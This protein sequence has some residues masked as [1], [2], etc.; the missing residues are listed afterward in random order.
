V[1]GESVNRGS[2]S[3]LVPVAA[4]LVAAFAVVTSEL[5]P[6]GLLPAIASD[7]EVSIPTAGLLISGYAIGVAIA[8]PALALVTGGVPR[9]LLLLVIMG[10]LILGSILSALSGSYWML[11]GARL[12]V[13]ACHGL[14]FG[15]A[16]VLASQLA[17]A[18]RQATAVSL[19]M[20]GV[21]AATILGVPLG[22]AIGN[23]ATWR[24][25]FWLIVALAVLAT[26]IVALLIPDK[27]TDARA[28]RS[29]FGAELSAALRPAALLCYASIALSMV[30][31]FVI[32]SYIVPFLTIVS[33]IS[34]EAVPWILL[35]IGVAGFFGNLLGGRLGDWS[36]VGTMV[37]SLAI[38]VVLFGAL[39]NIASS[40][41]GV[42]IL[43]SLI[44][45]VGF[46]FAA[47]AQSRIL[48]E[49]SDAPTFAS[50]LISTAFQVGIAG[51]AALGGAVIASGWGYANLPLVS[52]LFIALALLG[53]LALLAHDRRRRPA[54]ALSALRP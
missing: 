54:P 5:I 20:A 42:A 16:L 11:L 6:T 48:K 36:P 38:N 44:W 40:G 13:A 53:T 27:R 18:G 7:L 39:W 30:A 24:M 37:G 9:K 49:V 43:L 2:A 17:P 31:F 52:T 12:L 41:W 29:N 4:L 46:C 25:T 45:L 8:S 51:G 34:P 26:I 10:V 35:A 1:T 33:G 32:V 47:P 28:T 15:V 14:F 50:T 3:W 23:A 22:T 19:L 21:N